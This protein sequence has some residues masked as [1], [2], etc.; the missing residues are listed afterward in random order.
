[1]GKKTSRV[2]GQYSK[3]CGDFCQQQAFTSDNPDY[4]NKGLIDRVGVYY[5]NKVL[6]IFGSVIELSVF[7]W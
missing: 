5:V 3:V 1:M 4:V 6:K 2:A 7:M